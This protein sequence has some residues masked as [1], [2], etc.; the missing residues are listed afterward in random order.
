[1]MKDI[2]KIKDCRRCSL[3]KNQLPLLDNIKDIDVMWVGLSAK[4]V[5]DIDKNIPLEN[6]TNSGRI[7][8]KIENNFDDIS[9]YKTNL[10]KCLPLDNNKKLRYPTKKEI[11]MCINNLLCEISYFKPKV[12]FLLGN[13]VSSYVEKY[14]KNNNILINS[15]IITIYHPS[16]IWIYKKKELDKYIEDITLNIKE[17]TNI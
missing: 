1:M 16:Y 14:L 6:N 11:D 5:N 2:S 12:I 9:F 7:I 3:Y 8:E 10:V 4:E 15:K 13:K 17:N